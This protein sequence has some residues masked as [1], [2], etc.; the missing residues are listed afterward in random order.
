MERKVTY[1]NVINAYKRGLVL[2]YLSALFTLCMG[3]CV[4]IS[5]DKTIASVANY[6]MEFYFALIVVICTIYILAILVDFSCR[7]SSMVREFSNAILYIVGCAVTYFTFVRISHQTNICS[8]AFLEEF[9][10]S[11]FI[12]Y[13]GVS[14]TVVIGRLM[15][16]TIMSKRK[17]REDNLQTVEVSE[18]RERVCLHEAGHA[19]MTHL[20]GEVAGDIHINRDGTGIHSF[21]MRQLS[22]EDIR[23]VIMIKY[24]GAATEELIL[25]TYHAGCW[26]GPN[27][28]FTQAVECIRAYLILTDPSCS[29]TGLDPDMNE[30]IVRVSNELYKEAIELLAK[31]TG[32][33]RVLV[34]VLTVTDYISSERI[35][36]I[37]VA[38]E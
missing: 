26:V 1:S 18:S 4:V 15:E 7:N 29:K 37:L 3:C 17:K 36:K 9:T 21:T 27:S 6:V 10:L 30:K 11:I 22:A 31:H 32:K 24:A 28:D 20:L 16:R 13:V 19:V 33:I 23:K 5:G 8:A 25:G 34:S 14:L 38:E 12:I 2:S 35:S